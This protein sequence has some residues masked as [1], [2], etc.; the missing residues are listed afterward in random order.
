MA[1]KP[2][3]NTQTHTHTHTHTDLTS[4]REFKSQ[5]ALQ[6]LKSLIILHAP[7][8]VEKWTLF[9]WRGMWKNWLE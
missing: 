7:N 9:C 2:H 1:K 5:K 3:T 4:D 6:I 8:D